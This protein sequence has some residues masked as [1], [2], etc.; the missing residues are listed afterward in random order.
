MDAHARPGALN[1]PMRYASTTSRTEPSTGSSKPDT[2]AGLFSGTL[3]FWEQHWT[4]VKGQ[5]REGELR[6]RT[7]GVKARAQHNRAKDWIARTTPPVANRG[8]Y[9][10]AMVFALLSFFDEICYVPLLPVARL[11]AIP[12]DSH[13]RGTEGG[14]K[15]L[16]NNRGEREIWICFLGSP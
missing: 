14:K 13:E 9:V 8:R 4:K 6:T 10:F 11:L 12:L 5:A 7:A 15:G 1:M 2:L 3:H 16:N